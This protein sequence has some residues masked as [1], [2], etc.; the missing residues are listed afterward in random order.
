LRAVWVD[1]NFDGLSIEESLKIIVDLIDP[2]ERRKHE[3]EKQ[4][5]EVE[6][7]MK[8]LLRKVQ[9]DHDYL[10]R[11]VNEVVAGRQKDKFNIKG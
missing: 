11:Y 9:A 10:E 2:K 3:K 4:L 8:V 1:Y 6:M 7:A 5:N